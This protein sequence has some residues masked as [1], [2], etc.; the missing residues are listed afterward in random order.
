M[1][2][3]FFTN[4]LNLQTAMDI[5]EYKSI[6]VYKNTELAFPDII[7]LICWSFLVMFNCLL[8]GLWMRSVFYCT[9]V[10][11][12]VSI[13]LAAVS[14][15]VSVLYFWHDSLCKASSPWI[16]YNLLTWFVRW[17]HDS[18]YMIIH[19]SLYNLSRR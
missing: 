4:H 1:W 2:C 9:H 12:N 19:D 17:I 13:L 6:L 7:L 11:F 16:L 3:T 18:L 10:Y 5:T 8:L 15:S 14:S